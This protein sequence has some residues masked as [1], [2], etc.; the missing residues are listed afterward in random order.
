MKDKE[1]MKVTETKNAKVKSVPILFACIITALYAAFF[2]YF[3]LPAMNP[4]SLGFWSYFISIAGVFF[5]CISRKA[6]LLIFVFLF[7]FQLTGRIISGPLFHAQ[8][9]AGVIDVTQ[10]EFSDVVPE[11]EQ[12][13]NIALMDSDSAF[14]L[15]NRTMGSLSDVVSQYSLTSVCTTFNLNETPQK[16]INMEYDNIF[17]WIVN[18]DNGVPGYIMVDPVKNDS[19]FVKLN[20]PMTYVPSALFSQDLKRA[21]RLNHPTVIFDSYFF[22][23]DDEGNPWYI[24]PVYEYNA[25]LFGA[26]DV[27]GAILFDPCTGESTLLATEDIPI[28]VDNVYDGTVSAEKY[29]WYGM[30]SNGFWNSLFAKK[31]CKVTTDDFGYIVMNDDIYTYTGVTSVVSDESNI[32]FLMTNSRTGKS[33]FFEAAGA[34][35]YSAMGAAEG[36]VQE[37]GYKASFPSLVNIEG[38]PTYIMVLKDANGI[39][40]MYGLVNATNYTIVAVNESLEATRSS[41]IRRLNGDTSVMIP[42]ENDATNVPSTEDHFNDVPDSYIELTE[43]GI[44]ESMK[45]VPIGDHTYIYVTLTSGTSIRANFI[46][47]EALVLQDPGDEITVTYR[48]YSTPGVLPR[49]IAFESTPSPTN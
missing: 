15:A 21:I 34:E 13:S 30:Y 16:I 35:E 48:H 2:Y 4:H 11:R 17:K 36:E 19:E 47:F 12:I 49:L 42:T 20:T 27:S 5:L 25:G 7:G 45:I 43:T 46:D 44:I 23:V 3:G 22:E 39:V 38:V 26:R 8:D 41:Y 10:V 40:K 31:G 29:D 14:L 33:T 24:I 9:Y 18:K 1:K 28:W 37:K 6:G 32:G